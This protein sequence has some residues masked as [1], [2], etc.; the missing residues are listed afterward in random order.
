MAAERYLSPKREAARESLTHWIL[1]DRPQILYRDIKEVSDIVDLIVDAA[2]D[3]IRNEIKHT[4]TVGGYTN[5]ANH[6]GR[7]SN[8]KD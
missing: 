2:V 4:F 7:P 3:E 5:W 6:M 8:E 1:A